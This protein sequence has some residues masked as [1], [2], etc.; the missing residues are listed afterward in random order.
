MNGAERALFCFLYLL[1]FILHPLSACGVELSPW[2]PTAFQLQPQANYLYQTYQRVATSD[3]SYSHNANDS[4]FN[5]NIGVPY[6]NWYGEVDVVFANTR[7]RDLGLD[8]IY[9]S[10]RYQVMDDVDLSDPISLVVGVVLTSATKQ[11]LYDISSFHHGRFDFGLY[12]SAGKEFDCGRYWVWRGW[13]SLG[14]GVSDTGSP[15]LAGSVNFE[16]N[17]L[18]IHRF[19]V[20]LEGLYG[21]GDNNL[22]QHQSF[23]GYGPISHRSLDVGVSYAYAWDSGL[24][25]SLGYAFRVY[26]R[27]F[28]E[29][30]SRFMLNFLYPFS[31]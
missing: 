7:H 29:E 18:D 13:G 9:L 11:A 2:Y 21:F 14:L 16:K 28:P 17:H 5:L 8:S 4:F 26:A 1:S 12:A 15:W 19:R 10:G 24:E 6:Y 31:L 20:F 23:H 30:A 22:H 25:L 3:G 27:N